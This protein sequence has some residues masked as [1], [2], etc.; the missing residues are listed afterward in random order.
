MS[1]IFREVEEEVRRERLEKL[2]KDYGD[3]AM[4]ALLV[5][6]LVTAGIVL[7][8]RHEESRRERASAEFDATVQLA[9][10]NPAASI[11]KFE[12]LSKDAPGGYSRLAKFA[13]ADSLLA[14]GKR[15]KALSLYRSISADDELIGSAARLR[16]AW[17]IADFAPRG[18]VE[19]LVSP[20]LVSSSDWRF[21]AREV[22][23]Y[24]DFR[25][26][27]LPES[28]REC[29]S[30]ISDPTAASTIRARARGL[31]ELIKGGGGPDFG[32]VPAGANPSASSPQRP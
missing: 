24:T 31:A 11:D 16:A 10:T 19:N 1:D 25:L 6:V 23:A 4:A 29:Q 3:Y 15:D 20:L 22:M 17:A 27:D 5:V 14:V 12:E 32:S 18:A 26:G 7:W 8:Q 28:L 21:M 9:A 13:E 2:W 30:I